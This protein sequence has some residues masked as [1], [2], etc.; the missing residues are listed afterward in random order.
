MGE[1][2]TQHGLEL[3]LAIVSGAWFVSRTLVNFGEWKHGVTSKTSAVDAATID[4]LRLEIV[5]ATTKA[6]H[7]AVAAMNTTLLKLDQ[8]LDRAGEK[9]SEL[10]SRVQGFPTRDDYDGI[11]HELRHMRTVLEDI[12]RSRSDVGERIARLEGRP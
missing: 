6:R 9:S 5:D 1:W 2:L 10:A 7:D 3:A 11:W 4:R 8:R 12:Q